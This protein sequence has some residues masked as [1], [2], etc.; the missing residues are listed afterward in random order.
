VRTAIGASRG[1]IVRQ[2]FAE[3]LLLSGMGGIGGILFAAW[4]LR[5]ML[6]LVPAAAGLPFAD[7]VHISP[8]AL[9]LALGLSLLS[10]ILFGM[11]P[12][13]QASRSATAQHLGDAGRSR[14]AG[15]FSARWRNALIA[16]EI[17]LSLILIASAGL[18]VQTF[19]RLSKESW[20]FEPGKVLLIR[21]SLRGEQYRAAS[22]QHTYFEAAAGKL[23]EIPGVEAVSAVSFPPPL[24]L[25]APAR[26]VPAGQPLDPGHDPSA[27]TLSVLPGYFETLHTPI[28]SGR[29]ISSADSSDA[30]PV[31]VVSQS[32]ARRYFPVGNPVGQS[33]RLGGDRREW[34]IV[35]VAKDIRF[36]GLD[37]QAPPVL[38]FPHAQMPGSFMSFVIRTRTNPMAVAKTAERALWSLGKS[39]NVYHIAPLEERL[40]DSYWQSRFT[41]SL[42]AIFAGLALLLATAGVYG[43][44]SYMAAQRTQEIG[45][46]IALGALP[47]DVIWLVTNQ[48]MRAAAAGLAAGIAGYLAM[49]RVLAGQLFGVS[50]T[51]PLTLLAASFGLM[52]VS[53]AASIVPAFRAARIDPLLTLRR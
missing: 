38:Y 1:Q 48:G 20:G 16:A 42:L 10:S 19:L 24:T 11:A 50:A 53:M 44:M 52:I 31:A 4:S 26:F 36:A 17:G 18:L 23:R 45:I 27:T 15:R 12:A 49:S 35:G 43:V 47:F 2:L 21:N 30:A 7:Q 41:M 25:Y 46:R 51:D 6:A 14:S 29:S 5:P 34:R 8:E 9:A 33:F 28:V 40:S 32:V 37:A 13:R 22:A 39:M 3:N